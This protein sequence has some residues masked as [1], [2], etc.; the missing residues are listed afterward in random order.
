M[1][2]QDKRDP[3]KVAHNRPNPHG[4]TLARQINQRANESRCQKENWNR[5]CR[6]LLLLR[7]VWSPC[8]KLHGIELKKCTQVQTHSCTHNVAGKVLHTTTRT[9][10]TVR[11]TPFIPPFSVQDA[12]GT[13]ENLTIHLHQLCSSSTLLLLVAN[14]TRWAS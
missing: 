2:V 14:F 3:S 9:S 6:G 1:C 10:A 4:M 12:T 11:K 7:R 5:Y 8:Q 13:A